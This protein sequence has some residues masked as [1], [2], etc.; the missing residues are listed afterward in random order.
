MSVPPPDAATL[1]ERLGEGEFRRGYIEGSMSHHIANQLRGL[2]LARGIKKAAEV[3]EAAGVREGDVQSVLRGQF[4][5]DLRILHKIAAVFDV[6]ISARFVPFSQA[7]VDLG[8]VPSF[9]DEASAL[10]AALDEPQEQPK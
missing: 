1:W 8:W 2:M 6:A 10:E 5:G 9:A 4:R 7:V 3:A